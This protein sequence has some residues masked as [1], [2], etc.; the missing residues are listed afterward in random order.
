MC[1]FTSRKVEAPTLSVINQ[2]EMSAATKRRNHGS[3][4][5]SFPFWR[6]LAVGCLLGSMAIIVPEVLAG[7]SWMTRGE[8]LRELGLTH[9]SVY[10]TGAES[11]LPQAQLTDTPRQSGRFQRSI[12]ACVGRLSTTTTGEPS[13][14]AFLL[15]L[16]TGAVAVAT[17]GVETQVTVK[18]QVLIVAVTKVAT[19]V[20][21]IVA[22]KMV[23]ETEAAMKVVVQTL[24]I[25]IALMILILLRSCFLKCFVI[26]LIMTRWKQSLAICSKSRPNQITCGYTY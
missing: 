14:G 1:S 26:S 9:T 24:V 2:I 16:P 25:P 7:A 18:T 6:I 3:S 10:T 21:K 8:A 4:S 5:R 13:R 15:R 17:V 23:V 11:G 22:A 12:Y 19:M 20:V